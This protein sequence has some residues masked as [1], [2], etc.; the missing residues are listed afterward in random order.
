MVRRLK[1][2][3]YPFHSRIR[4]IIIKYHPCIWQ[5][6]PSLKHHQFCCYLLSLFRRYSIAIRD[7]LR[8][9]MT[10]SICHRLMLFKAIGLC[11]WRRNTDTTYC[12]V[13]SNSKRHTLSRGAA[14]CLRKLIVSLMHMGICY[15]SWDRW[16]RI[17]IT[18]NAHNIL[19]R[20]LFTNFIFCV[21]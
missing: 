16:V 10:S 4:P 20:V 3:K 14:L 21:L 18:Q 12:R 5:I 19:S 1:P 13:Y 7:C 15:C 2:S 11:K 6:N 8:N 17:F 9:A